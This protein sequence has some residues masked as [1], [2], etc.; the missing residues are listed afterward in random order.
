MVNDVFKPYGT[1]IDEDQYIL[2]IYDRWGNMVFETKDFNQGWDGSI[3]NNQ[4]ID[5]YKGAAI[6]NYYIYVVEKYSN[7]D[8]EYRGSITM[9]K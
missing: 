8:H 5:E 4:V 7:A 6:F 1:G 2:Q 3:N 9:I